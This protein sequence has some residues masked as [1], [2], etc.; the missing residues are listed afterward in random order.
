MTVTFL[1]NFEIFGFA[2][3][4]DK[5]ETFQD[6]GNTGSCGSGER[7]KND[8]TNGGY[9]FAKIA[10][11]G[12]GFNRRMRRDN[13]VVKPRIALFLTRLRAVKET[14]SAAGV[15]EISADIP[16]AESGAVAGIFLF[17]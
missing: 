3:N 2:F 13:A 17:W 7:V 10:H 6:C 8:P 14:G 5:F 1:R 15:A 16:T 9:E 11:E 4:P 12:Y